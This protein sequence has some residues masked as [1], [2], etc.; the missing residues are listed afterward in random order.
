[1]PV[2]FGIIGY[3]TMA[4]TCHRKVIESV[5]GAR[6]LA[7]CDRVPARREAARADGAE[8]TYASLGAML[9]DPDIHVV[10]I[11][12]PSHSHV[13]IGLKIAA[14]GKHILTEKPAARTAAELKKMIA[15][16]RRHGVLFTVFH[17]RR[18]DQ[19]F[20]AAKRIV[21]Q[22]MVGKVIAVEARWHLYGST[23][24]FGTKDYYQKWREM[25]RYGGGILLDLGVHRLDQVNQLAPGKP[26]QVFA[27][28]RGGVWAKD[29]DDYAMGLVHFD[30]G[31]MAQVE[32]SGLT[33]VR[34]P[35]WRIIG[36]RGMAVSNAEKKRFEIY[37]G[38][39]YKPT[40]TLSLSKP[41][42][43]DTVY[44]SMVAAIRDRR[45]KPVVDPES[46]VTT[47]QLIDAYRQ[48]ARTG[49]S[50]AVRGPRVK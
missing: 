23:A 38:R 50:A 44:R 36:T 19:D 32:V 49:R 24:G 20:L 41:S 45:K 17:N 15:A 14:A 4:S 18:F 3:G 13:H 1:M 29:C 9:K 11:C 33:T 37:L 21:R 7:V 16:A 6:L 46:V 31:M 26:D 34:L 43:W 25:K 40:R 47:M 8:R 28:I 5:P 12:T 35:T 10:S 48:S 39:G 27:A 30:D 42:R 22:K 2:N